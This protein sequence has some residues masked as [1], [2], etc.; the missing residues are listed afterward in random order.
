MMDFLVST[1]FQ[2]KRN[3][4]VSNASKQK[5]IIIEKRNTLSIYKKLLNYP[6]ETRSTRENF[7][8]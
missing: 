4:E 7:C 2:I 8:F 6:I 3:E 1:S 5:S